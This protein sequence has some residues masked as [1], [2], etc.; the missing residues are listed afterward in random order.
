MNNLLALEKLKQSAKKQSIELENTI[1]EI[2]EQNSKSL[3]ENLK[4]T[5][6]RRSK[7]IESSTQQLEKE[8]K[9]KTEKLSESLTEIHKNKLINIERMIES[10]LE[11]ESNLK[12]ILTAIITFILT[13]ATL[14][15]IVYFTINKQYQEKEQMTFYFYTIEHNNKKGK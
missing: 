5:H 7:N 2:H 9:A 4:A 3:L 12:I 1:T 11:K 6:D 8:L 15:T 10:K 13:I 14:S